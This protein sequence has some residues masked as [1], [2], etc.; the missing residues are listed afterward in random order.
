MAVSRETGVYVIRN[1]ANGKVYVGSAATSIR[2]RWATHRYRLRA[3][4]HCNAH[5]QHAWSKHGEAAFEFVV[6]ERVPP[7]ECVAREQAWIDFYRASDPLC[8]YNLCPTA[9]SA[10]GRKHGAETRARIG[11]ANA[12]SQ[13]GKRQSEGHKRSISA[14]LKGLVRGDETR[15]RMSA[16]ASRRPKRKLSPEHVARIVAANAG[17]AKP[18]KARLTAAQAEEIRARYR[19]RDP[20]NCLRALAAEYGVSEATAHAAVRR[21]YLAYA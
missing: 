21:T 5:L 17:R 4:G 13:K 9:G 12:I 20:L 16:A 8:G 11:A 7:Q 19:P 10:L 14:A 6:I 1:R 2:A 3:G 15:A 18:K